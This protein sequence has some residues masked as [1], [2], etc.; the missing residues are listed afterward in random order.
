ML[1]QLQDFSCLNI[2]DLYRV[3]DNVIFLINN[4]NLCGNIIRFLKLFYED[5]SFEIERRNNNG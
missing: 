5:L 2:L 3:R 4:C 1:Y